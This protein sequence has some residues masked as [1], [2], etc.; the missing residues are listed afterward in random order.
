ME[1]QSGPL[2]RLII[3]KS[4]GSFFYSNARD[5]FNHIFLTGT[6]AASIGFT[7][8][9]TLTAPNAPT[10][11]IGCSVFLA[12]FDLNGIIKWAKQAI[13]ASSASRSTAYGVTTDVNG[14]SYITGFFTDT[15]TFG[16]FTLHA[17]KYK[18]DYWGNCFLVKY[19]KYGIVIWAK[20]SVAASSLSYAVGNGIASDNKGN[21][22]IT[23]N[24]MDTVTF[25]TTT[26][27]THLQ[28]HITWASFAKYDTSGNLYLGCQAIAKQET[29]L[30]AKRNAITIDREGNPYITG[31]YI[32]RI[33]NSAEI[34]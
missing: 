6:F 32:W 19:N 13:G 25:G 7:S 4:S 22:Y 30:H 29:R 21:I 14:N 16:T 15:V 1:T 23:G 34:L 10:T 18:G 27:Y 9:T 28:L 12:M 5:H 8:T 20:Q 11:T 3:Q 31:N 26:L 17:A 33:Q 24:F 2:N